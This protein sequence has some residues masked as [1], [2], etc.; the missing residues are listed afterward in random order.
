MPVSARGGCS[1]SHRVLTRAEY[2][3]QYAHT[4]P[5][6]DATLGYCFLDTQADLESLR[7]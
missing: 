3:S 4:C 2:V 6:T 1:H 5:L 7:F